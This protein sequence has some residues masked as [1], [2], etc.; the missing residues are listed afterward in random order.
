MFMRS[1]STTQNCALP[2][3]AAISVP[4]IMKGIA[5]LSEYLGAE[6]SAAHGIND[7]LSGAIAGAAV[8]VILRSVECRRSAAIKRVQDIGNMNHHIRNGLQVIRSSHFIPEEEQ[9]VQ[10]IE[11]ATRRI[12]TALREFDAEQ[13]VPRL[14][15]RAEA[16]SAS[17]PSRTEQRVR[18]QT[19]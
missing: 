7:I 15:V 2:L 8:L 14:K 11:E 10:L 3:A 18:L 12:V 13:H 1:R 6:Q 17:G 19:S 4:V 5:V 9:R 16:N